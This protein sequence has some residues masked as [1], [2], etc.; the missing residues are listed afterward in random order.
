M[1]QVRVFHDIIFEN[2]VDCLR[3]III[4]NLYHVILKYILSCERRAPLSTVN[5]LYTSTAD[6]TVMSFTFL[7]MLEYTIFYKNNVMK[8]D[9]NIV[10]D[11]AILYVYLCLHKRENV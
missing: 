1:F 8:L 7:D 3:K 5:I 11:I 9:T 4:I 10:K 2:F 6:V